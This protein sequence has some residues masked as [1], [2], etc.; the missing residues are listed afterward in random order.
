MNAY[1]SLTF[2]QHQHQVADTFSSPPPCPFSQRVFFSLSSF[3]FS[4][5][6]KC[7]HPLYR[8]TICAVL[9]FGWQWNDWSAIVNHNSTALLV[10]ISLDWWRMTNI[11]FVID[12]GW[13]PLFPCAAERRLPYPA[14]GDEPLLQCDNCGTFHRGKFC[15]DCGERLLKKKKI[16]PRF[17]T[18]TNKRYVSLHLYPTQPTCNCTRLATGSLACQQQASCALVCCIVRADVRRV[19]YLQDPS[20]STAYSYQSMRTYWFYILRGGVVA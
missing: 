14:S 7:T 8:G 3:F 10:I 4:F 20:S 6:S 19:L 2:S 18:N 13:L 15:P 1:C 16:Y 5:L 11:P 12:W 17:G 9:M